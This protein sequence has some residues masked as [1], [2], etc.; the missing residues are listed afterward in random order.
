M[1]NKRQIEQLA[2]NSSIKGIRY[3]MQRVHEDVDIL[4]GEEKRQ[5]LEEME[6]IIEE[7]KNRDKR[8]KEDISRYMGDR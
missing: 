8:N 1:L 3:Y 2:R 6:K 5:I 4:S 7:I